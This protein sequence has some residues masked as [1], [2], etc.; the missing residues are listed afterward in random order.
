MMAK[1]IDNK[2]G[3]TISDALFIPAKIITTLAITIKK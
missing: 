1:N 2:K 3:T